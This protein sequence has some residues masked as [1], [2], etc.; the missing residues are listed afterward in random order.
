[1]NLIERLFARHR[2]LLRKTGAR[3]VSAPWAAISALLG[4]CEPDERVSSV[5]RAGYGST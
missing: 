4:S 5:R 3:T 2:A 1:M